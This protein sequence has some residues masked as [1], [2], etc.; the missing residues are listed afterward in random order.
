M[1]WYL[2]CGVLWYSRTR[3]RWQYNTTQKGYDLHAGQLRQ[4]YR[5]LCCTVSCCTA[6]GAVRMCLCVTLTVLFPCDVMNITIRTGSIYPVMSRHVCLANETSWSRILLYKL[7]VAYWDQKFHA[8]HRTRRPIVVLKFFPPVNL[9]WD[10]VN[11]FTFYLRYVVMLP[12]DPY[13]GLPTFLFSSGFVTKILR[14][15]PISPIILRVPLLSVSL[16]LPSW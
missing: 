13:T 12:F 16:I 11:Q 10:G 14:A 6:T 4:G 7:R 3:H 2:W 15:F 1:L 9:I 5:H 8:F